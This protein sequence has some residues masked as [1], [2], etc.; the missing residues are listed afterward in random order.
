ME[1]LTYKGK[2]PEE[3]RKSS[4]RYFL[5][6]GRFFNTFVARQGNVDSI[7]NHIFD[8]NTAGDNVRFIP[9]IAIQGSIG[10][11][12]TRL[13]DELIDALA[14]HSP[15]PLIVTVNFNSTTRITPDE[16]TIM[17]RD[18]GVQ[19]VLGVRMLWGHFFKFDMEFPQ[20][21]RRCMRAFK[22]NNHIFMHN[23]I[24]AL[25]QDVGFDATTATTVILV[26]EA[27]KCREENVNKIV[28]ALGQLV[29]ILNTSHLV[30]NAVANAP[31]MPMEGHIGSTGKVAV[32]HARR[33]ATLV[34]TSLDGVLENKTETQS[35][36]ALHWEALA[37]LTDADVEKLIPSGMLKDSLGGPNRLF[38]L[39]RSDCCRHPRLLEVFYKFLT[40]VSEMNRQPKTY[41][42]AWR[43]GLGELLS[44]YRYDSQLVD[45]DVLDIIL[46]VG[47]DRKI[48][49]LDESI[50][51]STVRHL[52][53]QGILLNTGVTDDR[54]FT[55]LISPLVL[56]DWA[57]KNQ[58][59]Q[60]AALVLYY[61]M[62][63][64][65]E[66][67]RSQTM[68][69]NLTQQSIHGRPFEKF[70]GLW[71]LLQAVLADKEG[72]YIDVGV[73]GQY[74]I[75][76]FRDVVSLIQSSKAVAC[77]RSSRPSNRNGSDDGT[78][79][80]SNNNSKP[81]FDA[82]SNRFDDARISI[83]V[84][85]LGGTMPGFDILVF[86]RK[87]GATWG[88]K[89]IQT[90]GGN[91]DSTTAAVYE[92]VGKTVNELCP[93]FPG[94]KALLPQVVTDASSKKKML[95]G[96]NCH[97]RST[98]ASVERA[99]ANT[100]AQHFPIDLVVSECQFEYY[101]MGDASNA[102]SHGYDKV[103]I[104][105]R[106]RLREKFQCLWGRV[107]IFTGDL[108]NRESSENNLKRASNDSDD[109]NMSAK[110]EKME[111][112]DE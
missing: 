35:K 103:R 83:I 97:N 93:Y 110:R 19:F 46:K 88:L 43:S 18:A 36:H 74:N 37:P 73:P 63:G 45:R 98:I 8:K 65:H 79:T 53:Q 68:N 107:E 26:D 29:D 39:L 1:G 81:F 67:M 100:A 66:T 50:G 42:E 11:G 32:S 7:M 44:T 76:S 64:W 91:N 27:I 85:M 70:V 41:A 16:V 90:K 80:N 23:I 10:G 52:L 28:S 82:M 92:H 34:I 84:M 94:F 72:V 62:N 58:T 2:I 77:L 17:N 21:L 33:R 31:G 56:F 9:H 51:N 6:S 78:N 106:G 60:P 40:D 105:G 111:D 3:E 57:E 38:H 13:M 47:H 20:F 12:K 99:Q 95:A 5:G 4:I 86:H 96:V 109:D 89:A 71:L 101:C 61:M 30:E 22:A 87:S 49:R 25:Q 102:Q 24:P 69:E 14:K 55:P 75:S 48:V 112:D 104:Y 59:S 15:R 108:D 54:M